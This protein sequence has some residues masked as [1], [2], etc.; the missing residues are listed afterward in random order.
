MAPNEPERRVSRVASK[1]REELVR[2]AIVAVYLYICFGA[3]IL[4]K[5]AVLRAHGVGFPVLGLAVAKALVLGK[6]VLLGRDLHVGERHR[7]K[8][9]VYSVLY[10][11]VVF[12]LLL[13]V[14]SVLEEAILA[15]IHGRPIVEGLTHIAGS[16]WPE[17][18]VSCL[19]LCLILMPYFSLAAINDRLGGR[20]LHRM[21]FGGE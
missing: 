13:L 4:Y 15:K 17:I 2:Y 16:T 7:D 18:L 11:V 5:A 9:L 20:R 3:L 10:Q 12:A 21:F 6:F 1:L 8:P 19:L 14:L